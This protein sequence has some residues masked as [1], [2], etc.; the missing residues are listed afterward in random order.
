M[1]V[2]K[3]VEQ[4]D[5]GDNETVVTFSVGETTGNAFSFAV[6]EVGTLTFPADAWRFI[7]KAIQH[8]ARRPLIVM[9]ESQP[10]G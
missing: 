7:L 5:G 8:G 4:E 10:E 3:I 1:I 6:K 9:S 2:L